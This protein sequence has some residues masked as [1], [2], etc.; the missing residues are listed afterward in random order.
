MPD[1]FAADN[2]LLAPLAAAMPG[3]LHPTLREMVE[4]SYLY[5]VEDADAVARLGLDRLAEIAVGQVDRIAA[6]LGGCQFYLPR[7]IGAKLS[8][9]DRQIAEEWRGNN[10]HAL[11]RKH[12]I[13]EMRVSQILKK[14]RAEEFARRQGVL[15][16]GGG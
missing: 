8:A 13:S 15:G 10:G 4:E 14:W 6:T 9:R 16:I 2:G 3:D 11:A 5:L 12:G 1:L 7:G